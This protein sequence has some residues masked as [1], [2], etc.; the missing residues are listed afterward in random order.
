MKLYAPSYYQKFACIADKC[1]HS[2]CVGWEIDIDKDTMYTYNHMEE[3][4][5]D[6]IRK[7][8]DTTGETPHFTLCA[9]ERCPHLDKQGL[10]NIITNVGEEYLCHVCREHPRFYNTTANGM[11]VG[12]GMA[13]EEACRII[14]STPD[15]ASMEPIRRIP[16]GVVCLGFDP[17]PSRGKVYEILSRDTLTYTQKIHTLSQFF[18]I[19]L[20][21]C[22]DEAWRD[23]LANLEY[24]DEDHKTLFATYS[25]VVTPPHALMSY[26]E[27]ALAYFVYRHG[28]SAKS[29]TDFGASLGFG[30]FCVQL[31][32]CMAVSQKVCD[33]SG[34]V[35][36]GRIVSEELEYSEENT[37]AIKWEFLF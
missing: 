9:G 32:T 7:S 21:C 35:E 6:V 28:T 29:E 34:L 33:L 26:L 20:T 4:Y 10:C 3:D 2:C 8:I 37:Q 24:L 14:L 31:M 25:S 17:L 11:E 22:T 27:R 36:I 5:G 15:F 16:A 13:C 19:S 18:G 30:L 23:I 12:L 1:T